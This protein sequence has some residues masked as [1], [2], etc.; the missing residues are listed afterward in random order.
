MRG[1]HPRRVGQR[2][3]LVVQRVVELAG[4]LVG[5][6]AGRREQVGAADVADEERVAGEH[7][8]RH[9]VVGVL[10]HDDRRSTP[11]CA[12]A[13][14]GPRARRRRAGAVAVG[15]R[16]DG[17]ARP[18]AARAVRDRGAG[19]RG[20]L[21]VAAQEVGVDVGLDDPL[22]RAA[23]GPSASVEVLRRRRAAGR[24][25]PRAPSS[26]RR[27]GRTRATGTPGSTASKIK[28]LLSRPGSQSLSVS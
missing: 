8:V 4:E 21:E 20:E 28:P 16:L 7:A 10:E 24:R 14:R 15:E 13:S 12:R 3:Q 26:R 27:P 11:A 25:R 9:G 1:E 22:D 18:V 23:R 17:E 2:Q 19:P 6:D 5:G